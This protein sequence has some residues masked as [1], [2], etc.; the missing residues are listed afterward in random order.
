MGTH[1]PPCGGGLGLGRGALVIE[2]EE[3]GE[4]LLGG[5]VGGPAVGGEDGFVEGAVGVGEPGGASVV[6]VGEG[7]LF[8]FVGGGVG[9]VE[10]VVAQADELAAA[11]AMAR[12][13]AESA[14]EGSVPGGQGKG[15]VSKVEFGV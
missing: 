4:D 11:S 3:V 1:F 9:R 6:E 10:P 2:G 7:A 8:E 15:K 14:S 13:M 5:E 12:T